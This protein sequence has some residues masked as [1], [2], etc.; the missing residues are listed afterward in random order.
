MPLDALSPTVI[1][2]WLECEHSLTLRLRHSSA[3][4]AFGPFADLV[5]DKGTAHELA[6]RAR[7]LSQGLSVLDVPEK[8]ALGFEEWAEQSSSLLETEDFDVIYQMPLVHNG[9]KGVADF[10][11]R[12]EAESG[13]SSWEPVDAKLARSEGKPGH[14]LQLCYYAEAVEALVGARPKEMHLELGS[15]VRESYRFEEFGPYWRRMKLELSRATQ[16]AAPLTETVPEPCR[17]CEFCDF[18]KICEQ[19]WRDEDSLV[20]VA[21]LLKADRH[22]LEMSGVKTLQELADAPASSALPAERFERVRRQAALQKRFRADEA[23]PVPFELL[24]PGED[25]IWGHG[26]AHLPAPDVGDVFFDLEGHPL[27]TAEAG[28]FF[29][30]GLLLKEE[31][32]WVYRAFWAHSLEEQERQAVALVALFEERRQQFPSMHV[33]HYNHTERSALHSMTKDTEASVAFAHLAATGFFV[34]LLTVVKNSFQMGIESY[35]LKD[36]E[37]VTGFER[38]GEIHAGSGAVLL[39]EKFCETGE[40]S[41]LGEIGLYNEN[42]VRS[43][44]V[45]RDWLISQRPGGTRWRDGILPEFERNLELDELEFHLLEFERETIEHLYGNLIGY[46]RRER[47]AQ[48]TPKRDS[49]TMPV[50]DLIDDP[51]VLTALRA[52]DRGDPVVNEGAGLV[53]EKMTFSFPDQDLSDRWKSGSVFIGGLDG[54]SGFASLSKLDLEGQRLVLS[55]K[56]PIEESAMVPVSIIQDDWVSPGAKQDALIEGARLLLADPASLPDV[57]REILLQNRPR[58]LPGCGPVGGIFSDDKDDMVSWVS[59][60]DRSIVAVQGPPG[61]GKTY[62]GARMVRKLLQDG[63]RVGITAPSYAAFGNFMEA[64]VKLYLEEGDVAGLKACQRIQSGAARPL[65]DYIDYSTNNDKGADPAYQLVAGTSWFFCSKQIAEHPVDY[66]IVDE[67]GQV[68]LADVVAMSLLSTNVVLL[69]DP[70]QLEQ[71]SNAV[72]PEGSGSTSLEHMMAG[73]LTIADDRGVFIHETWRMHPDICHFI[74][75]Q[76]YEDRLHSH[77]SCAIQAVAGHGTGLR[78]MEAS[79]QGNSTVSTQEAEMI[80]AKIKEL[81]GVSWTNQEGDVQALTTA[82]FMVVAPFNDQKDEIR[83]LLELDPTTR[84][85][86]SSVGTVD[87]FQ[88]REAPVVFFSMTTSDSE[89]LNRGA[90]FLFS[91]RRLNVAVSR[92]R[93]LAYLICTDALLGTKATTVEGMRLIGTLNS[94]VEDAVAL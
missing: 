18:Q 59:D 74:S 71:V 33:Y 43:T 8:G 6:V 51:D 1:T 14:L 56:H 83:R 24:V 44:L 23:G 55:W 49:V 61:T 36:I 39:Y 66:L 86:T 15:G 58:F 63:K 81:L 72:H 68:S 64:V 9:I 70:L 32:E 48:L 4:Q 13:F 42:D 20:F 10:L 88:G 76:I 2:G 54:A 62:R 80:V 82:D 11:V 53:S 26:Y 67:A 17:F 85:I 77:P 84:D 45:L 65:E 7:Y 69:G 87:K 37:K 50:A 79:H 38:T 16:G 52:I 40:S 19:R 31:G 41:I 91:R 78:W 94:F 73:A 60:L 25:P 89:G 35:G 29:L 12:V 30:F 47:S 75:S 21:N 34:D 3:P 57:T 28:I 5:R 92:A 22:A 90:D 46:W 93:C 27:F